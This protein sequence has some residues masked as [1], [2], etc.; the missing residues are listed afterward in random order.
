MCG[1]AFLV[2]KFTPTSI[3][4]L[5]Q[6]PV[7]RRPIYNMCIYIYYNPCFIALQ[8]THPSQAKQSFL[9]PHLPVLDRS[10]FV[11]VSQ[12]FGHDVNKGHGDAWTGLIFLCY[13]LL[14][15]CC[16]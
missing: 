10:G 12:G 6:P 8:R 4:Y 7:P 2:K 11:S 14:M 15:L 1:N 3:N 13:N 16:L 9:A 5:A